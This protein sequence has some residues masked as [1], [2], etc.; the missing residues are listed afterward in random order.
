[1]PDVRV[2]DLVSWVAISL[3]VIFTILAS[4]PVVTII[5]FYFANRKE[6]TAVYQLDEGRG[7][8]YTV[9]WGWN[10][11]QTISLV[12][13]KSTISQAG[14]EVFKSVYN[15]GGPLY[16]DKTSNVYYV[17]LNFGVY[18]IDFGNKIVNNVCFV[19]NPIV[20]RLTYL[21]YFGFRDFDRNHDD[22]VAFMPVGQ[23]LPRYYQGEDARMTINGRCG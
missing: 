10:M 7:I 6:K 8:H 12:T 22:D 18:K 23:K 3:A 9:N 16:L 19:E 13:K 21:G 15:A 5:V 4:I 20:D 17:L 14:E 1:M 11:L 2:H